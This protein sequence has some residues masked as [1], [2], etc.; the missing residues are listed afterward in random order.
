MIYLPTWEEERALKTIFRIGTDTAFIKTARDIFV[1]RITTGIE[2]IEVETDI[3]AGGKP[4][5]DTSDPMKALD[6]IQKYNKPAMLILLD[7]HVYFDSRKPE[8]KVIRKVRDTVNMLKGGMVPKNVILLS[9]RLILPNELQKDITIV[10]FDLPDYRDI[11]QSLKRIIND[12]R[13]NTK[14]RFDLDENSSE[15]LARAA[16]GLTLQEAENAFARAIVERGCLDKDSRDI[17]VEEK[18]QIIKK[19][20]VL[21]YIQSDLNL[22]DVGGLGNLKKWLLKR[23]NSWQA[24]AAKYSLPA[25]KGVLITGV[26]GCGK[27]LTAKAISAMWK[28]PLLRMDVGKIFSGIVGSSEENMRNAIK[29]AE[30]AAPSILWIDEIEK[31]F[32]GVSGSGDSGTSTRVFGTFLTWMQEKKEPVFVVATANNIHALPSEMMRKGRFDEIFFVDLPT[33]AERKA[34][35]KV[36]LMRRLKDKDVRGS[37]DWDETALNHLAD[38]TEGFVGAEIENAVTSGLFEAFCENRAIRMEDFDK[39][40]TNTVPLVVTQAEQISAIRAWANVRAVAATAPEDRQDYVRD[41][42]AAGNGNGEPEKK[43]DVFQQRGG[44]TIDI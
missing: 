28:L 25:P 20:G 43:E 44:R 16:Q 24:R 9:P 36:H 27:S 5:K 7:F 41:N 39:A 23:N 40:I 3:T 19:T 26:P 13:G 1:W 34:I 4:E 33:A 2:R 11:K 21:E 12:N 42:S 8:A 18:R 30:A 38:E 17:I 10:D 14:I 29:T 32:S 22:D 35:F 37:F 15:E 6:F 31:G